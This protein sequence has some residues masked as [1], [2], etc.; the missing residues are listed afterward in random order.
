MN[1]SLSLAHCFSLAKKLEKVAHQKWC[2]HL[3]QGRSEFDVG[4][5]TLAL[6]Y[7]LLPLSVVSVWCHSACL[8]DIDAHCAPVAL[9]SVSSQEHSTSTVQLANRLYNPV[10]CPTTYIIEFINNKTDICVP[11]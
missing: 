2:L 9:R 6:A 11:I 7:A 4:N 3:A 1:H 8:K 5:W 10:S